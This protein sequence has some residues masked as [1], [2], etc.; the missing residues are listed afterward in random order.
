MIKTLTKMLKTGKKGD[1]LGAWFFIL[2]IILAP[3][4]GTKW[5]A[6]Y[7]GAN[8]DRAYSIQQTS[9]GGYI[10]AGHTDYSVGGSLGDI[11]ILKLDPSGNILWQKRYGGS[12]KDRAP[13]G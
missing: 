12:S 9:D 5:A 11:W 10:V 1:I 4:C 8:T 2:L 6:T 3:G 13:S 7:G